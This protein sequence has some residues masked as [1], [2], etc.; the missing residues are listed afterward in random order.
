VID[1]DIFATRLG[2][3]GILP[4][5]IAIQIND[6]TTAGKMPALP[7]TIQQLPFRFCLPRIH[8]LAGAT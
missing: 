5:S 1:D 7:G 3:A 6:Q 2:G 8:V 4:A